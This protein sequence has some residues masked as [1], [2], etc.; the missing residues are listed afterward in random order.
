MSLRALPY[1]GLIFALSLLGACATAPA[2]V[3]SAESYFKQGEA[4]YASRNYDE[5]VA[6]WKKVRESYSSPELTTQ[7][8]L[9]IA[10][11]HFENKAFIEA[12]AAYEDFRKLHPGHD[13]ASYA[14]YRLGLSHY[15][16]IA[17]IDTD[18]TPVKNAVLTLEGFLNQYPNSPYAADAQQKLADCRNK[19]LEYENYVGNF[20]LKT[21]KYGAAIKRLSEAL[22]RF[23]NSPKLDQT[24]FSLGKSYIKAGDKVQ[25]RAA[26]K[27]LATEFPKSP[28][29]KD[30]AKLQDGFVGY[31]SLHG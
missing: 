15:H 31:S 8:E 18:Q 3:K 6:Q 24:L 4:A 10:D 16:Q 5:A 23:P 11:A 28:L 9:K 29:N 26:L 12:A 30:A 17:G 20:Y 1:L 2:P 25:G 27:R 14:L 7:A 13:K 22:V 19:Q 21:G